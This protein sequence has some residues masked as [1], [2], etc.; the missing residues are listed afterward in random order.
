MHTWTYLFA[1]IV[2]EVGGTTAMKLSEGF[3]RPG[4]SL[5][6]FALYG[7]SFACLAFALKEID[8]GLA[9]AVWAGLGTALVALVGFVYFGES[10]TAPKLASLALIV[11]GVVGLNLSGSAH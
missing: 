1:A 9:Y 2:L 6:M 5:A 10:I 3:A 11:G 4:A 7:L 8:L